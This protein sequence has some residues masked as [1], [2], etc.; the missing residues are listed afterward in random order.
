[1]KIIKSFLR[2][3]KDN[4]RLT[5]LALMSIHYPLTVTIDDVLDVTASSGNSTG[6]AFVNISFYK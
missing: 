3:K 5:G 6:I 1:M 4:E 2:N